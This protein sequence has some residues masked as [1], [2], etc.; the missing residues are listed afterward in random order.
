MKKICPLMSIIK[1]K[2]SKMFVNC[3]NEECALW[4]EESK[5]CAI[6]NLGQIVYESQQ[7]QKQYCIRPDGEKAFSDKKR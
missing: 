1:H 7:K 4:I 2:F 6:K 3:V 5:C